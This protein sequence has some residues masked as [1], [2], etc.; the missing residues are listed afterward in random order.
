VTTVLNKKV[1]AR[2]A[3][4]YVEII[5]F[6]KEYINRYQETK[7]RE[8]V[9]RNIIFQIKYYATVVADSIVLS[10]KEKKSYLKEIIVF[11]VSMSEIRKFNNKLF[12]FMMYLIF[13]LPF[14]LY[15]FKAIDAGE[16]LLKT[17]RNFSN[18]RYPI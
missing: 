4:Q 9:F 8:T 17:V 2:Y 13:I 11:P 1:S 12:F 6:S 16:R 3:Q 10:K 15:S 18:R 14:T 5:N 7:I